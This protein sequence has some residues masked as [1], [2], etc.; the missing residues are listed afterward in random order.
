MKVSSVDPRDQN[1]EISDPEY[2]VHLF[3]ENGGSDEYVL[4]GANDVSEVWDWIKV[5]D[6]GKPAVVYVAVP[7]C[8]LGLVRLFGRD[9]NEL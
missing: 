3:T 8:G 4:S 1:W 9:P 2:R 7:H 6:H 5:N